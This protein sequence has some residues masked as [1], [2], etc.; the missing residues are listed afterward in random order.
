MAGQAPGLVQDFF[1]LHNVFPLSPGFSHIFGIS[2]RWATAFSI[3]PCFGSNLGFMYVAGRQMNAMARSGLL[4]AMFTITYGEHNTPVASML[5]VT[6]VG[7]ISLSFAW[8]YDPHTLLFRMAISGGCA[9]YILMLISFYQFRTVY[10]TMARSF[11]NPLGIPSAIYGILI[12][13]LKEVSVLF[14]LPLQVNFYQTI[15]FGIVCVC[16]VIHYFTVVVHYQTFSPEEQEKFMKTY[17]VNSK[18]YLSLLFCVFLL[19]LL[20][21]F[22]MY[23][24]FCL[25]TKINSKCES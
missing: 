4:P 14:I 23:F 21:Y 12:F 18:K 2:H 9:A 25:I 20:L 7:L 8:V 1:G 22:F 15:A 16:A 19:L 11:V 5:V 3:L 10:S 24:F 6:V 17:V 13:A